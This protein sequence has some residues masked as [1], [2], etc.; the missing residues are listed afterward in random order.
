MTPEYAAGLF[1]GEGCVRIH[2]TD[3]SFKLRC[4]ICLT[5]LPI[6]EQLQIEYGG[7]IHRTRG[8]NKPVYHWV[9]STASANSFLEH[10]YPHVQ[11]KKQEIKIALD[12]VKLCVGRRGYKLTDV[13]LAIRANYKQELQ[14]LKRV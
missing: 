13:E 14:R 11:V 12:F 6:L 3:R 9:L 7:S 10:I 8:T 5:Y 4:S 2:Q 1:D